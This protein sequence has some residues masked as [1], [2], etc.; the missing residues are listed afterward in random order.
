MSH[1]VSLR[2]RSSRIIAEFWFNCELCICDWVF[3]IQRLSWSTWRK[4][5]CLRWRWFFQIQIICCVFD[6]LTITSSS[7]TKDVSAQ[8]KH[9]SSSSINENRW[10]M[11]IRKKNF[12]RI[13]DFLLINITHLTKNVW[14]IYSTH[15]SLIIVNVSLN[16]T[17]IKCYISISQCHR[18]IKKNM[19]C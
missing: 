8:K 7:M 11:L 12:E 15:T 13:E 1:S 18:E 4:I 9:D 14:N 19:R 16:V 5:L 6:I 3:Q 10:C 17:S 2:R